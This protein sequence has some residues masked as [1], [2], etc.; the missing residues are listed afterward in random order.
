MPG[1]A[2]PSAALCHPAVD[3]ALATAAAL[4]GMEVVF[5]GEW[6]DGQFSFARVRGQ[7]A[8]VSE[9]TRLPY[10]DTLCA[11]L[12][13]GAPPATADAPADPH[14]GDAP[15]RSALGIV[16]YVG[17][18]IRDRHGRVLGTLCGIDRRSVA[19][20]PEAV[21]VLAELAG[22]VAAHLDHGPGVVVRRTAAG[23]QVGDEPVEDLTSAM[24]LAD[25]LAGAPEPAGRPS[26]ADPDADE[27]ARL[28]TAVAQLEHALR[29]RVVVEQAIG[30]LAERQ[31]T[32]PRE[33]FDRLRR[34][35]RSRGRRV[36]AMAGEVVASAGDRQVPLP[37]ELAGG[38]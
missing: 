18:P 25:L 15:A 12:L 19:V 8:G 14:Y 17:V 20:A 37:P 2:A 3:A 22:I 7:L 13:D 30:V 21:G 29:A 36:H 16:S 35:A 27:T 1:A 33:A 9:G 31:R 4:L 24:V 5:V 38:R 10:A 28:R 6:D 32:L 34:A 26:R 23:W 11:R